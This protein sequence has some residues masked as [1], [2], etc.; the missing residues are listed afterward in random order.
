MNIRNKKGFT[1]TE[2]IVVIAIIGILAAVLIPSVVVYV[3][4]AQL[5][6][7]EQLAAS[8]TDEIERFCIE[9]DLE[10]KNLTGS[11]VRTI[12]A[13][14]KYDLEPSRKV[15]TYVYNAS[16][17]AV[18]V[19]KFKEIEDIANSDSSDPVDPSNFAENMYIVGK[20]KT[21]FEKSISD[22]FTGKI[23]NVSNYD[24]EGYQQ[25]L[26]NNFLTNTIYV[27]NMSII[28]VTDASSNDGVTLL[29]GTAQYKLVFCELTFNIPDALA[30]LKDE[31]PTTFRVPEIICSIDDEAKEQLQDK[32]LNIN[33]IR[34]NIGCVKIG[35]ESFNV[36]TYTFTVG[37]YA[38]DI[39]S[40]SFN[41][42]TLGIY[43][44]KEGDI[45]VE[46]YFVRT[47]SAKFF[48]LEG[49][50][51]SGEIT[52]LEEC[53][54]DNDQIRELTPY[55]DSELLELGIELN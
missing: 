36:N 53:T 24:L 15:Y 41:L 55:S 9:N 26:I 48:R 34:S 4:K 19:L 49:L 31:L 13:G 23:S 21:D 18:Q 20:G 54:R 44:V 43:E 39:I 14:K 8:M 47:I 11:D 22:L 40:Q 25:T 6:N 16:E 45:V 27:N 51:A 1:L 30:T 38:E 50:V 5:S 12:L 46:R 35:K 29:E 33:S 42:D 37:S 17:K 10:H 52:F 2:M 32:I 28:K 7:D 3:Q